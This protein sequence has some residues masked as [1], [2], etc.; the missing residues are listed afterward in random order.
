MDL[1]VVL[2][3]ALGGAFAALGAAKVARTPSMVARAGHVG[4]SVERYQL[5]GLAELA[6]AI[7]IL[8]GLAYSPLGYSAGAGLLA[9][10]TG[11]LFTHARRRDGSAEMAPAILFAAGIVAYLILLGAVR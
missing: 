8:L 5:I 7:G 2:A 3:V 10:M 6:G 9:L 4:F 1:T 11:A